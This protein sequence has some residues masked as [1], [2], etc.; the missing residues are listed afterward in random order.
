[1]KRGLLIA[2]VAAGTLAASSAAAAQEV[3]TVRKNT[4][5]YVTGWYLRH[6]G[7]WTFRDSGS[8]DCD[9]GRLNRTHWRCRFWLRNGRRCYAGR[10]QVWGVYFVPKRGPY[11]EANGNSHGRFC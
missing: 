8:I 11:Y 3:P 4:A 1:M 2:A 6:W 9:G 5:L 10:V 7:V